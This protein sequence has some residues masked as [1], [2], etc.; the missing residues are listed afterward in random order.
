MVTA[1]LL[2]SSN[3]SVTLA[4]GP[5]RNPKSSRR[6]DQARNTTDDASDGIQK[7]YACGSLFVRCVPDAN[8]RNICAP[9]RRIFAATDADIRSR[10]EHERPVGKP[11]SGE[12]VGS[13]TNAA[14]RGLPPV[15]RIIATFAC[16]IGLYYCARLF[17]HTHRAHR[18][19]SQEKR[20][21]V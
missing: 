18:F 13:V 12:T 16:D 21:S 7:T 2:C 20:L 5:K 11:C 3:W 15:G 19:R 6:I 10:R 4:A 1:S 14:P 9:E 17:F 8:L